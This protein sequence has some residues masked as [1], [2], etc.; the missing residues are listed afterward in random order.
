[1]ALDQKTDD[2]GNEHVSPCIDD[3][4]ASPEA[5][6]LLVDTQ[7]PPRPEFP[8]GTVRS[9]VTRTRHTLHF[10]YCT[11]TPENGNP[12]HTRAAADGGR[13]QQSCVRL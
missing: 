1:M 7:W 2:V 5:R 10:A 9:G 8:Y 11:L 12:N 3:D 13:L 6:A 4:V